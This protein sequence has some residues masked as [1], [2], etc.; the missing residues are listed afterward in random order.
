[1]ILD[2]DGDAE[3]MVLDPWRANQVR[4]LVE[5]IASATAIELLFAA[6]SNCQ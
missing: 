3:A 5:H 4:E 1:M 2:H 6:S